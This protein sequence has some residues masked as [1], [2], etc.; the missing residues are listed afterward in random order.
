MHVLTY[1]LI[2]TRQWDWILCFKKKC[3]DFKSCLN[4]SA[5]VGQA[6]R[7]SGWRYDWRRSPSNPE[8]DFSDSQ[9][10][11]AGFPGARHLFF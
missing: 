10:G 8:E 6:A 3:F 2:Y 9:P 7:I 4:V 11:S 1:A 5:T